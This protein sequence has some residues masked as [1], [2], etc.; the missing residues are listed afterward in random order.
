ME[1]T[2]IKQEGNLLTFLNYKDSDIV[3]NSRKN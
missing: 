3:L 1:P 2:N